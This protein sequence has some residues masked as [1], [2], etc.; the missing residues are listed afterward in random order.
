[1]YLVEF[2]AEFSQTI[3][4]LYDI[5]IKKNADYGDSFSK[6]MAEFGAISFVVRASD[7]MERLK[8]LVNKD[9]VVTNESFNDTVEDLALYCIMYLMEVENKRER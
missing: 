8:N 2:I 6:A 3:H 5:Y 1:M 9:P 4:K 7:K